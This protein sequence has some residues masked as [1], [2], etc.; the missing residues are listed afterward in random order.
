M[1]IGRWAADGPDCAAIWR[2]GGACKAA[3]GLLVY[4]RLDDGAAG[5]VLRGFVATIFD[6]VFR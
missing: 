3:N 4:D 2:L 1:G 5:A 6:L